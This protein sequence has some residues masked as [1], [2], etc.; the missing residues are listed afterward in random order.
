M[1]TRNKIIQFKKVKLSF[2]L[3]IVIVLCAARSYAGIVILSKVPEAIKS[4]LIKAQH[5]VQQHV[6]Q[7]NGSSLE[8]YLFDKGAHSPHLT[9][10]Y[11]S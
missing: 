6:E 5:V 11:V 9:L 7:I 10:A 8:Q 3:S 4:L 2:L 1:G